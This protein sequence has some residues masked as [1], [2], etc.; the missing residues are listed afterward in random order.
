MS[1]RHTEPGYT[2]DYFFFPRGV[3][4][5]TY[6]VR[7][8]SY[9]ELPLAF[10]REENVSGINT[11]L[12]SFKGDLTNTAAYPDTKLQ[13]DQSIICF[14]FELSYW[15]EPTTGE[16]VKFREWCEGDWVVNT[17]TGEKLYA[18]SRWGGE[19]SGDDLIRRTAEVGAMVNTDNWMSRNIPL[20]L[21]TLGC[22]AL[23]FGLAPS[24]L[25]KNRAHE[26][27]NV[28]KQAA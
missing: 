21:A 24:M 16:V 28:E 27:G 15:I 25:K 1:G 8:T 14:N 7:N 10:Q 13:A 18:L 9:A 5:T 19:N 26:Q 2:S 4:K 23:L 22:A 3:Q 20:L 6:A 11:Y 12:Y 17:Q